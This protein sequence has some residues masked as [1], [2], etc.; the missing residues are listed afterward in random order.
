MKY[1]NFDNVPALPVELVFDPVR[2]PVYRKGVVVPDQ[3]WIINPNTDQLINDKPSGKNHN[4]VNYTH[5]WDSFREG[6]DQSGID[7]SNLQVR[8]NVADRGA[9]FSADIVF[10]QYNYDRIVGEATEMKMRIIDSHDMSF[11]RDIRCMIMRLACTNGMVTVGERLTVKQKHTMLSDPEKLG[12]VVAEYPSRLEDE[13][14]LYKQMMGTRVTKDQAIAFA[15]SE[16][17]TYRIASGIKV[18]EKSVE[19]FARI[20]N[21]YAGLGETGYRLYNVMTHIGTHVTGRAD[22]DLARKQIRIE[23]RVSDIVQG[24]AF[25]Q[26]AGLAA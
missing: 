11:R 5:V 21:E 14:H 22:T 18:N 12:A 7:T 10:K 16:V 9:A 6:V 13:A 4:P 1:E 25:Q 24:K 8:F 20:W 15:R 23:D 17:A 19:E 2:E 3:F 26:L